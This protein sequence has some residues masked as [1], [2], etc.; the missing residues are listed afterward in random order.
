MTPTTNAAGIMAKLRR[1]NKWCP[2]VRPLMIKK[3]LLYYVH[4]NIFFANSNEWGT[5]TFC[6]M[7]ALICV[8]AASLSYSNQFSNRYYKVKNVQEQP[9]GLLL[10]VIH[11]FLI[12]FVFKKQ[13][14]W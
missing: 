9:I 12:N 14:P 2:N 11:R 13:K 5:Y 10:I 4:K 8:A 1:L 3:C 7:L 6:I